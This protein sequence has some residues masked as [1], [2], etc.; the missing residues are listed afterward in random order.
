MRIVGY[1]TLLLALTFRAGMGEA[2]SGQRVEVARAQV[3]ALP[4]GDVIAR[5]LDLTVPA[6]QVAV[7]HAHGAGF[8]YALEGTHVLAAGGREMPLGPGRAAWV[9]AQEAHG[10]G[11]AAGAASRFWFVLVGPA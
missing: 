4:T 8:A 11:G 1:V 5:F 2:A 9:G 10:H 7:T 3:A 6:G